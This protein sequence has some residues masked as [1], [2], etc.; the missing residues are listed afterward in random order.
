MPRKPSAEKQAARYQARQDALRKSVKHWLEMGDVGA[1]LRIALGWAETMAMEH[2]Q[3]EKTY[4]LQFRTPGRA[5]LPPLTFEQEDEC[6]AA[7]VRAVNVVLGEL[8]L[9]LIED[10]PAL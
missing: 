7:F 8:G 10:V 6:K 9:W 4:M 5:G 1:A 2:P 3:V